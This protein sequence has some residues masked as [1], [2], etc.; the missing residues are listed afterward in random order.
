MF[1]RQLL[2]SVLLSIIFLFPLYLVFINSFKFENDIINNPGSFPEIFTL[3]NYLSIFFKSDDLLVNS[4]SNSLIF[5]SISIF[6]CFDTFIY[7]CIFYSL[8]K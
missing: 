6:F 2:L 5:T 7:A 3:K 1:S 4:F 8:L